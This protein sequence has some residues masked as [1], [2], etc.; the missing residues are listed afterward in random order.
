M[1]F[2][3]MLVDFLPLFLK[4]CIIL[5]AKIWT[6]SPWVVA[7]F[8][9]CLLA[10][11]M[12]CSLSRCCVLLLPCCCCLVRSLPLYYIN[13]N[14]CLDWFACTTQ[15]IYLYAWTVPTVNCCCF[16][17]STCLACS[18]LLLLFYPLCCSFYPFCWGGRVRLIDLA[19]VNGWGVGVWYSLS[20]Y[21]IH[22]FFL[23]YS[24]YVYCDC[25]NCFSSFLLGTLDTLG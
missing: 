22:Y 20:R 10:V 4:S 8:L 9:L 23:F 14:Y 15:P 16:V 3:E 12:C 13:I 1:L 19:W 2:C 11:V 21:K 18:V 5:T 25:F 17:V 6:Y 7:L 24:T